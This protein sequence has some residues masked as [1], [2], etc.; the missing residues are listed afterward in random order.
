MNR[1]AGAAFAFIA[2]AALSGAAGAASCPAPETPH[3]T[4][5]KPRDPIKPDCLAKPSGCDRYVESQYEFDMKKFQE[6]T[7]LY[8]DLSSA[9]LSQLRNYLNQAQDFVQCEARRL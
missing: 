9:Y 4:Q 6:E 3:F 5:S 7:R 2:V 1:M 8:R